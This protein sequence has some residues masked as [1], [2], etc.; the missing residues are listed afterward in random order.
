MNTGRL[1]S[2]NADLTV[3][4]GNEVVNVCGAGESVTVELS[5]VSAGYKILRGIGG[6]KTLRGRLAALSSHYQP[7]G[8]PL[9]FGRLH[10]DL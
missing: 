8:F 1:L 10:A 2:V 6:L 5:S 3:T 7:W 4:I 9:S